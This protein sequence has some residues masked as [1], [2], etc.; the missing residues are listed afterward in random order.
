[1]KKLLLILALC[2]FS[3][4]QS[5]TIKNTAITSKYENVF[6][7]SPKLKNQEVVFNVNRIT[8]SSNYKGSKSEN[9]YQIAIYGTINKARETIIYNAASIEE[10]EHYVELFNGTY[11]KILLFENEYFVGKKKYTDTS[12]VVEY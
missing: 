1:M 7:R 6:Y 4:T 3:F 8:F 10:L 9:K 2:V 11:K 5:Q 12:I